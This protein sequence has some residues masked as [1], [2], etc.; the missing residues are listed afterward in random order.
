MQVL[1]NVSPFAFI[2]L[3]ITQLTLI[4]LMELTPC[5]AAL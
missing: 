4:L 3:T 2:Y 5:R 1:N